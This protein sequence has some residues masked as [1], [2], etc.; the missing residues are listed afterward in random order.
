M[1]SRILILGAAGRFGHAAAE[2]FRTAGWAVTSL[3]RPGAA[4]RAPKRTQVVEID[5]LDH[6]AV[7]AAARG[8]EVVLHALNPQYTDWSRLALPL[9]YSAITAAETAGATLLFPGNLYNYGKGLP[10]VIDE[11]TPMRPSSRKGQ[12]RVAMEDRMAEAAERGMRAIIL[13]AGDFYGGG[14]GAWLDLVIAREIGR[15]R[16]TYPGPLDLVHEWAYLPDLAAA[17]VRLAAV[18]DRFGPFESFGFPGHAITG[19]EFTT[20]IAR[21]VGGKLQ[22]KPMTWWLVH[23][24]RPFV[25]LCREL[26]ETAYLWNEPH[27][28]DGGKLTAA[29]GEVPRTALDV[30]VARALRQLGA[31]D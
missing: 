28:I 12:L 16:L 11:A 22:V 23:A 8:A 19:R 17:L 20:A 24:L 25:P 4:E 18:R 31:I 10:P 5:A 1:T 29:I 14:E 3:V 15:G 21:A 9:A 6:A 2:A 13:R 7:G 27:R 26:S 30:A